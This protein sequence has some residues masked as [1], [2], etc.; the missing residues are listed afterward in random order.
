MSDYYDDYYG[1]YEYG[2]GDDV[3][4]YLGYFGVGDD[5]T[6][7]GAAFTSSGPHGES[8]LQAQ[9][10]AHGPDRPD[11]AIEGFIDAAVDQVVA[12][13][14]DDQGQFQHDTFVGPSTGPSGGGGISSGPIPG[15]APGPNISTGPSGSSKFSLP[16]ILGIAAGALIIFG[17]KLL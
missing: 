17:K 12:N 9:A 5:A 3:E 2:E 13:I 6:G 4:S 7:P 1:G 16:L 11:T 8:S 15:N 14:G 10:K